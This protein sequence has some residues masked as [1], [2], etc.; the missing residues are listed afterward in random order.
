MAMH[1]KLLIQ[2]NGRDCPGI[3][4]SV[5]ALLKEHN[6]ELT[7]IQQISSLGRLS[8]VVL[9]ELP[10]LDIL[11]LLRSLKQFC[12]SNGLHL[13]FE[14]A[15]QE[16]TAGSQYA[17]TILSSRLRPESL[18]ALGRALAQQQINIDRMYFLARSNLECL[19]MTVSMPLSGDGSF[20][21]IRKTVFEVATAYE[22]DAAVQQENLFR[23][24]KRMIVMDMDSTLIRQE[25]IDE[26]A[27]FAGVKNKVSEITERAM[28]GELDFNQ[29]LTERVALLKGLPVSELDKVI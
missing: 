21:D 6:A 20:A 12:F 24:S 25:V 2:L 11:P 8:L 15:D 9:V 7:D 23:R 19:E 4:A 10:V 28:R 1:E 17:L 13:D 27:D 3:F 5:T 18:T 22:F 26:I 29:A 14:P 16:R